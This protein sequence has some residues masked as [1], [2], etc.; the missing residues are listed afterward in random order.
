[1]WNLIYF[2]SLAVG[3][4]VAL[5]T[6]KK[7]VMK[8]W[9]R[10]FFVVVLS[11]G[12]AACGSGSSP[13]EPVTSAVFPTEVGIDVSE[14]ASDTLPALSIG[15][16][17]IPSTG[18]LASPMT[19][20]TNMV[21]AT[22]IMTSGVMSGVAAAFNASLTSSSTQV[23]GTVHGK[24]VKI[25]FSAFDFDGDG[26]VVG[27]GTAALSDT[28]PVVFRVWADGVRAIAGMI[29][30]FPTFDAA[31]VMQSAGAG[32]LYMT[33]SVLRTG[34]ETDDLNDS[35]VQVKVTYDQTN[36]DNQSFDSYLK[37]TVY[38]LET[39]KADISIMQNTVGAVVSGGVT[40][41]LVKT[42]GSFTAD[43]T[44]GPPPYFD[45]LQF[46]ASWFS[47]GDLMILRSDGTLNDAT[48]QDVNLCGNLT[49]GNMAG[50]GPGDIRMCLDAGFSEATIADDQ[51]LPVAADPTV[52]DFPADFPT[53]PTF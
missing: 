28:Q 19:A 24:T 3:Y 39:E 13:V 33:P 8:T 53:T 25:D 9:I 2:T 26:T 46:I 47:D 17:I 21:Q 30:T 31:G 40:T 35:G 10:A 42:G 37:G 49:T 18:D 5:Q 29:T 36:S 20:A 22:N 51:Q 14:A 48:T 4:N 43:A 50:G 41:Y 12:V 44:V 15:K 34:E 11:V 32:T 6:D 45:S 1:M 27:S 16:A 38:E 23:S 7:R 52:P